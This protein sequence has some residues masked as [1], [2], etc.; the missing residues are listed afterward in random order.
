MHEFNRYLKN[1]K[2]NMFS[3]PGAQSYQILHYLDVHLEDK[4]IENIVMHIGVNDLLRDSSE[5]KIKNLL[6]S[7]KSMVKK[8]ESFGVRNIYISGLVFTSRINI[9][10]LEKVHD[11]IQNLCKT[12]GCIYIDNRNITRFLLYK[13]GLHLME[14]GKVILARNFL[15]YLND[16]IQKSF[17]DAHKHTLWDI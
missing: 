13:D 6:Q 14:E 17:L 9:V 7:L 15:F 10:C 1:G 4:S 5:S 2:A 16:N 11:M 3:F 12:E 8:C